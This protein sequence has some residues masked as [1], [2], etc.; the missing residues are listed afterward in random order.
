MA[1]SIPQDEV[2]YITGSLQQV[3]GV[4]NREQG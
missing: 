1:W 4:F 3:G 2:L